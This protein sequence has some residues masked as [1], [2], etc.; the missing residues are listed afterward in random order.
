MPHRWLC[1][2]AEQRKEVWMWGWEMQQWRLWQCCFAS[3]SVVGKPL[4][5]LFLR[6]NLQPRLKLS[7]PSFLSLAFLRRWPRKGMCMF[8]REAGVKGKQASRWSSVWGSSLSSCNTSATKN[9]MG[10]CSQ[11]TSPVSFGA[12]SCSSASARTTLQ[13]IKILGGKGGGSGRLRQFKHLD[14]C[15]G[16]YSSLTHGQRVN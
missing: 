6:L 4:P 2:R 16:K 13:L 15:Y 12:H 8:W 5:W 9:D 1:A 14:D 10:M 11:I 7:P 3:G